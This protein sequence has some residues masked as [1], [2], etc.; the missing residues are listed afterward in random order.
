LYEHGCVLKTLFYLTF[1]ESFYFPEITTAELSG[2]K[3]TFGQIVITYAVNESNGRFQINRIKIL[4]DLKFETLLRAVKEN[5]RRD[6]SMGRPLR[7]LPCN[8]QLFSW[9]IPLVGMTPCES[10]HF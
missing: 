7:N 10:Y 8:R 1:A 2:S 3:R 5:I 6:R 9:K 4:N